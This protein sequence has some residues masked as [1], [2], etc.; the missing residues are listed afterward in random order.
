[1]RGAARGG[2]GEGLSAPQQAAAASRAP[3]VDVAV[4]RAPTRSSR[5]ARLRAPLSRSGWV[6]LGQASRGDH[7][8]G[9][10]TDAELPED[11]RAVR[12]D[13]RFGH[14]KLE[15]DLLVGLALGQQHEDAALLRR[16]LGDTSGELAVALVEIS[17]RG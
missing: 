14:G 15:S 11:L 10:A 7:G 17:G 1:F 2:A 6:G 5:G 4:A 3:R 13:R 9:A 16:E 8:L 12:L